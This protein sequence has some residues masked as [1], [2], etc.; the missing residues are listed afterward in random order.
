MPRLYRMA[1]VLLL[2]A[3]LTTTAVLAVPRPGAQPRQSL[4]SASAPIDLASQLW[5][6]LTRV[7][8]KNG[9]EMDPN[10]VRTKNG[11]EMDPDG[12][13]LQILIPVTTNQDKGHQVDPNG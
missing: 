13:K 4:I 6:F 11:S 12:H 3:I 8:T 5:S 2:A 9:S 10:G 7:W 1:L